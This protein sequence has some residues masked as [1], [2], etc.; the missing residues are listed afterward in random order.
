[1]MKLVE[2]IVRGEREDWSRKRE[3]RGYES[4]MNLEPLSYVEGSNFMNS[5]LSLKFHFESCYL[6][7]NH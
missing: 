1:M 3:Y 2:G 4:R 7:H 5:Y 6:R